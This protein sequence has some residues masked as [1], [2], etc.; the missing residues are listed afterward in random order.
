LVLKLLDACFQLCLLRT[1]QR[2]SLFETHQL[3][4]QLSCVEHLPSLCDHSIYHTRPPPAHRAG[5]RKGLR[6]G[7]GLHPDYLPI[8]YAPVSLADYDGF[9]SAAGLRLERRFATWDGQPYDGG[10]YAVS[11]HLAAPA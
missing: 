8:A 3:P 1:Q 6:H 9:C 11:V 5:A 4:F 2:H 7:F 10:G